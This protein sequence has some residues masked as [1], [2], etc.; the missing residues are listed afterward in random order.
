[1]LDFLGGAKQGPKTQRAQGYLRGHLFEAA[2][3]KWRIRRWHAAGYGKMKVCRKR[4]NLPLA[5]ALSRGKDG[6]PRVF[7]S[8]VSLLESNGPMAASRSPQYQTP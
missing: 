2:V 1:L 3:A 8:Y 6:N 5:K 4:C 7:V